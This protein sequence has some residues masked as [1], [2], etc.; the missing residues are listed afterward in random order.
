MSD[1]PGPSTPPPPSPPPSPGASELSLRILSALLMA[2][3]AIGATIAGGIAFGLLV[4]CVSALAFAEWNAI[5]TGRAA[6]KVVV[7]ACGLIALS[8]VLMAMGAPVRAILTGGVAWI[9]VGGRA[10]LT[11][12]PERR[13]W[14]ILGPL[15]ALLPGLAMVLL[16]GSDALGLLAM[17]FLFAVVWGTDIAAYFSGRALGGPKL[18]P[19]VSPKK[20]WSGALGGLAAAVMLGAATVAWGRGGS[21]A[22]VMAV[23]ALLSVASQGGDLFES[24][25]KR[26]FGVKDSG[27]VIP[28]HGGI[29]D[30][31]DGLVAAAVLAVLIGALRAGFLAPA[32]GLVAW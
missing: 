4:A 1:G 14:L 6:D 18:W 17:L 11:S 32:E 24:A 3:V 9:L 21:I 8:V 28:G 16:R 31:I 20:T 30:R 22:P 19:A 25:L 15:Y 5:V 23:A 26:R 27:H 12:D 13:G 2:P 10:S 29:L 7:V